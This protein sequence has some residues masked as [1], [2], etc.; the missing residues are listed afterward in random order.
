MFGLH[1]YSDDPD[2][3][4]C[5][6]DQPQF[7]TPVYVGIHTAPRPWIAMQGGPT[8]HFRIA[9]IED[10]L[11]E[12]SEAAGCLDA[13][14]G[15]GV[16]TAGLPARRPGRPAACHDRPDPCSTAVPDCGTTSAASS[17]PTP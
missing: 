8:F 13:R 10:V 15:E 1:A 2:W 16:S 11:A 6:G 14:V 17:R 4:G 3:K 5:W 7:G 9:A 12:A